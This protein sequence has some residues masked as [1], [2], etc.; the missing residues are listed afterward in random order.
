MLDDTKPN[1]EL[2]DELRHLRLRVA[3]LEERTQVLESGH[4]ESTAKTD[5]A[6]L[7]SAYFQRLFESSPQAI[8]LLDSEDRVIECNPGFEQLFGYPRGEAEGRSINS[9]VVP[10][11]HRAEA[12]AISQRALDGEIA[13]A[14]VVRQRRDG[15]EV[16][17]RIVGYPVVRENR[18]TVLIGIYTDITA[19]RLAEQQ[20]RLQGAAMES[21]ANAIFITDREGRIEWVNLA[22]SRLSG[23]DEDEVL[24]R[25]P[26]LLD[27]GHHDKVLDPESWRELGAGATSRGQVVCRNKAGVVYIVEQMVTAIATDEGEM[28]HFVVVHEDVSA[29]IDAEQRVLHLSRHDRL[30]DLPNRYTLLERIEFELDRATRLGN[31]VAVHVLDLDHFKDVNDTYGHSVGDDLLLAVAERLKRTLRIGTTL[32]RI[33]GDEFA[34]IQSDFVELANVDG[35]ARRILEAFDEPFEVDRRRIHIATSIGV[36]VRPPKEGDP[37]RLL[38]WADLALYRAKEDGRCTY[39]LHTE[40]MDQEARARIEIGQQLHGVLAREELSLEFQPQVELPSGAVVA[41]E[42]LARWWHPERGNVPPDSFIPVAEGSGLIVGIGEWVLR[43]ACREALSWQAE[44][45]ELPVAVNVSAVQFRDPDLASRVA[46]IL[47]E[48]GL[49]PRCLE[50]EIT[51]GVLMRPAPVVDRNL[52]QLEE[53]GVSFSL[54]DFGKGYSSL[55][56]LRRL[57]LHKLK[58]DR[59]FVEGLE[60]EASHAVI[61]SAVAA[62]GQQLGLQVVAEGVEDRRQLE[63]LLSKGCSLAQGNLF[64]PAVPPQE[65]VAVL[66]QGRAMLRDRSA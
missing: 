49:S 12:A 44:F 50:L 37:R 58:I 60:S 43:T 45:G 56:Y 51:E 24:G 40:G 65:L 27:A 10:P 62:L 52:R 21:A 8:V 61:V 17:V 13:A 16:M 4:A 28:A 23:Y 20:L 48:V 5:G 54:D 1:S 47:E 57:R 63:I 38:Q 59:S 32:A 2:L 55:E 26:I 6:E 53:I 33:G 25:K 22:F 31:L 9:L 66:R 42:A 30:T 36:A 3:M 41:V 39:R 46:G 34:V 64:C 15:S 14:E 29:R 7:Y 18:D 19:R 35:L 11:Q